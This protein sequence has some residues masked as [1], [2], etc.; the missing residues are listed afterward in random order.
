MP[1]VVSFKGKGRRTSGQERV[2]FN[3][4]HVMKFLQIYSMKGLQSIYMTKTSN[5]LCSLLPFHGSV[6]KLALG[7]E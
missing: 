7:Y 6:G 4:D 2:C 5:E 1:V 3:P